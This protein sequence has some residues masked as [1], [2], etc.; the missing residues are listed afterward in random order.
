MSPSIDS[1]DCFI[2]NDDTTGQ[3]A[4]LFPAYRFYKNWTGRNVDVG[5]FSCFGFGLDAIVFYYMGYQHFFS[6]KVLT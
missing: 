1:R 3:I 4:S 2:M 5:G 6:L